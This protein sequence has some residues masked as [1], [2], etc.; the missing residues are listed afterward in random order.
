[1]YVILGT[2]QFVF[3]QKI[4]G[5]YLLTCEKH[6][7]VCNSRNLHFPL[8]NNFKRYDNNMSMFVLHIKFSYSKVDFVQKFD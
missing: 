3:M 8:V 2:T 1:M 4:L 5:I 6:T 7:Y